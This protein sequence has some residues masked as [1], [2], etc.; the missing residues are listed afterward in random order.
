[1]EVSVKWEKTNRGY[2]IMY[3]R[4]AF[5][6]YKY[7]GD[8]SFSDMKKRYKVDDEYINW[9]K[10]RYGK[11]MCSNQLLWFK[12][13]FAIEEFFNEVILPLET[14]HKLTGEST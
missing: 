1:M 12:Y 13:E 6:G 11:H 14:M 5:R 7:F 9:M 2:S 3:L 4:D 8:L 10:K